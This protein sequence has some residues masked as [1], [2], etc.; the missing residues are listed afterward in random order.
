MRVNHEVNLPAERLERLPA[1][2]QDHISL[3]QRRVAELTEEL[4][5]LVAPNSDV[6]THADPYA[7]RPKPVGDNPTLHHLMEDGS[8]V[9]LEL[10][11]RK[12]TVTSINSSRVSPAS[13][14]RV[15]NMLDIYLVD[16]DALD[17][18]RTA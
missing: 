12:I 5:A 3:L 8:E 16:P 2:A 11:R 1:Y 15:A 10:G 14:P 13:V 9:M 7:E 17:K 18:G 4:E 6:T